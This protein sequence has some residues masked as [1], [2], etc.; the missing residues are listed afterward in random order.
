M[1]Y[2]EQN[3]ESS[4]EELEFAFKNILIVAKRRKNSRFI[5][6]TDALLQRIKFFIQT[7]KEGKLQSLG[8]AELRSICIEGLSLVDSLAART[9]IE[10]REVLFPLPEVKRDARKFGS[11]FFSDYFSWKDS[12][13]IYSPESLMGILENDLHLLNAARDILCKSQISKKKLN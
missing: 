5:E 7:R 1:K 4:L 6:Q 10:I 3:I 11:L 13:I 9:M 2:N 12:N 8:N